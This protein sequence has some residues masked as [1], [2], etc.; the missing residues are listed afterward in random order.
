MLLL[1]SAV[2]AVIATS[3]EIDKPDQGE[4]SLVSLLIPGLSVDAVTRHL[5]SIGHVLTNLLRVAVPLTPLAVG[6]R[7]EAHSVLLTYRRIFQDA[8][9]H[10]TP[11]DLGSH[12]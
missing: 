12:S 9:F 5:P 3:R 2:A 8:E 6:L 10:V 4:D 7:C 11:T 1:L